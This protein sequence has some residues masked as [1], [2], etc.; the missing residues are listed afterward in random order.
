MG[1][2]ATVAVVIRLGGWL[3]GVEGSSEVGETTVVGGTLTDVTADTRAIEQPIQLEYGIRGSGPLDRVA[4]TGILSFALDNSSR[5]SHGD[6]GAYS[7]G[8]SN[9]VAGFDLGAEVLL[10]IT[11]SGTTYYKFSGTLIDISPKAGQYGRQFVQCQAVD[12]MDD[13]ARSRVKNVGIQTDKR[14]DELVTLLV[15]NCVD[16]QPNATAYATGQSTF[17]TSLDNI[18][19]NETSVVA[20]LQDAIISELG[21]IYVKGDTTQGGTLVME[22]RHARP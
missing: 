16:K 12:W 6:Q 13:A 18:S 11:Y 8:H 15:E 3:V 1:V 22:D 10:K 4:S 14:A 5:N 2:E 17:S 9:A 20:A 7:P 19:D 21:Y